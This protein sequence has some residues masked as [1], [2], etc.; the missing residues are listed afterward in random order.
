MIGAGKWWGTGEAS[1]APSNSTIASSH[2]YAVQ[3]QTL[4]MVLRCEQ[5][6]VLGI[7]LVTIGGCCGEEALH[8]LAIPL[9]QN[10]LH[11]CHMSP[12]NFS[13]SLDGVRTDSFIDR[14]HLL[15]VDTIVALHTSAN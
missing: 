6:K 9:L 3:Y 1:S 4:F 2:S 13:Y 10:T 5:T 15:V 11:S 12:Q 8:F 7:D 14:Y